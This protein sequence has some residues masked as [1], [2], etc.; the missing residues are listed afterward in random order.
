LSGKAA[1]E[2]GWSFD[3]KNGDLLARA[4]TEG[5]DALVTTDQNLRYQQN[6]SGRRLGVVVL[7]TSWPRI[8]GHVNLV[9]HAADKL[10]PGA[11][12]EISFP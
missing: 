12:E 7:M 11:Y 1:H 8:R 2:R 4:E 5:F 6:L 10:R 3:L 9:A